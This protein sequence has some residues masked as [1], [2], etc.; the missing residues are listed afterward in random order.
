MQEIIPTDKLWLK[1]QELIN[2][3]RNK[4]YSQIN[5]T[6][7]QTYWHIGKL[8]VEEEQNGE[9]RASYGQ[10][11]ISSLANKFA[12]AGE[13]GFGVANLGHMR[14]FYLQFPNYDALR[15]E[16]SWTHYRLLLKVD[17]P[18][19]RSFYE[20]EC[21]KSKWSTRELDRQISSLLYDRL[22]LSR[23]KE[24]LLRLAEDGAEP[25]R[26]SDVIKDPFVLEFVGLSENDKYLEKD[27]EQGLID[28]LQHFLLEL[29]RGFSFV[30]RQKRIT[31]DG[32][33]FY[34]D[35]VFYHYVLKCFILVDLKVG[36]LMHQ[37][38]GQMQMYI[39]YYERELNVT[40]DNPPIGIILCADKNEAVVKYT[41]NENNKQIFTSKYKLELP[42]EDELKIELLR[43]KAEIL[44]YQHLN[45]NNQLDDKT[46]E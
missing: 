32:D 31:L 29:G 24:G 16:L 23:D 21:T 35:L 33:H 30:A 40:G 46:D 36:R 41:M 39:N 28:K 17:E 6:I 8:I 5:N 22:A 7:V 26:P 11:I 43:E 12:E 19:K 14:N 9:K 37:D 10:A 38:I 1:V 13:K 42:T 18:Q 25:S 45:E 20:V 34:I 4:I 27:L 3:A 15:R 2:G 44:L